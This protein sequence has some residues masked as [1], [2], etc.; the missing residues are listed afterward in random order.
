MNLQM[1]LQH[2]RATQ[3]AVV[4][5]LQA[6]LVAWQEPEASEAL[7]FVAADVQRDE[8]VLLAAAGLPTQGRYLYVFEVDDVQT[9][10]HDYRAYRQQTG[11][12]NPG[13]LSRFNNAP[14]PTGT[15]YV[16]SS[17]GLRERF[18]M[19]LGYFDPRMRTYGLK[20][21]K[22][23]VSSTPRLTFRY[24]RLSNANQALMQLLEDGLWELRQ[25]VFGKKGSS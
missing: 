20:L 15:L 3:L 12:G 16:G 17:N 9:A 14:V 10:L 25:P 7:H 11:P 5:A 24:C 1:D 18:K 23:L 6:A 13:F 8:W 21:R 22:W 4:E 2:V 19:H